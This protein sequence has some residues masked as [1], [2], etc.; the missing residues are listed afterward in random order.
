[1]SVGGIWQDMAEGYPK[2]E[3][4]GSKTMYTFR[5]EK[6]ETK[7]FFYDPAVDFGNT[8]FGNTGVTSIF[9]TLTVLVSIMS[10]FL[11]Q[12]WAL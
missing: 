8:D 4:Q 6:N 10:A 9:S 3:T 5:F 11:L 1:M 2:V 7:D 12:N